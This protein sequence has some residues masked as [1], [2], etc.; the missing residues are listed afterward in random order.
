MQ[1]WR[2]IRCLTAGCNGT[3]PDPADKE[4]NEAEKEQCFT[5][6]TLLKVAIGKRHRNNTRHAVEIVDV[7]ERAE[8]VTEENQAEH[9]LD[10][11]EN[12]ANDQRPRDA[13]AEN[14]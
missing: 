13:T 7:T 5:G 9:D 2:G 8:T 11:D 12:L 4:C 14:P 3:D 10:G 1:R 6:S